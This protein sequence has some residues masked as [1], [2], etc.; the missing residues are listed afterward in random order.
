MAIIPDNESYYTQR[1]M[2]LLTIVSL[3]YCPLVFDNIQAQTLFTPRLLPLGV[4]LNRQAVLE[5]GT[6]TCSFSDGITL[7][8]ALGV[9]CF[10]YRSQ[11]SAVTSFSPNIASSISTPVQL[12]V[13][14]VLPAG[15]LLDSENLL[16]NGHKRC[17]FSDKI[18]TEVGN[19][20]NCFTYNLVA[21]NNA[22]SITFPSSP[23]P[24]NARPYQRLDRDSLCRSMKTA[25]RNKSA[26]YTDLLSELSNRG[27]TEQN[28]A[29]QW[30]KILLGVVVAAAV[31]A[32]A[33]AG[34]GGWGTSNAYDTT[35]SWDEQNAPTGGRQWV[36]RGEQTGQYSDE[37]HC[38]GH[39]Q[40]DSRWPG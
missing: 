38:A 29:V 32:A 11:A 20:A 37:R 6:K 10:S 1:F 17:R 34:G 19:G 8:V 14:R 4:L 9:Q 24:Y 35:F 15:V 30:G 31:V 3:T 39:L 36:C 16:S 21:Q 40:V 26:G 33:S 5:N 28:C 22:A 18:I 7:E 2:H 27:L 13:P 25:R 12:D 23:E